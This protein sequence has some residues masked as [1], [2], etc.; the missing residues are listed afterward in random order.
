MSQTTVVERYSWD[1]TAARA[2]CLREAQRL[3]RDPLAAEDAVQEALLR[4]WRQRESCQRPDAPLA[5]MVQ[6]TRNEALR[7]I[8]RRRVRAERETPSAAD[9][10]AA[11][12]PDLPEADGRLDLLDLRRAL[13]HVSTDE[14]ELLALRYGCDL[15]QP[16]I[17][18]ALA[19][20]EGTVKVRLHRA[21]KR[22]RKAMEAA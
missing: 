4:A 19:V 3:L 13:S 7:L 1:W 9:V 2:R 16:D 21:R 12:A 20:P 14:R 5:W 6:I 11:S 10:E 15:S 8:G 17:A 22:V 18:E